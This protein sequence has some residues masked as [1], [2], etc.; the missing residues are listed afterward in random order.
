MLRM[1]GCTSSIANA[2]GVLELPVC[3][4]CE[5]GGG[6][7]LRS[8]HVRTEL[9]PRFAGKPGEF[10][11]WDEYPDQSGYAAVDLFERSSTQDALDRAYAATHDF[12]VLENRF[13]LDSLTIESVLYPTVWLGGEW[14]QDNRQARCPDCRAPMTFLGAVTDLPEA[15]VSFFDTTDAYMLY[16]TCH[17]CRL[18]TGQN[19]AY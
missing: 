3:L 12:E 8:G 6:F 5:F 18:M 16:Q 1:S 10:P 13:N 4:R 19:I 17:R 14:H 11:L 7:V 9:H 2:E 15:G